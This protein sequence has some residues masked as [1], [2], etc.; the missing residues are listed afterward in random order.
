MCPT[1]STIQTNNY[2]SFNSL[3]GLSAWLISLNATNTIELVDIHPNTT[4]TI[5]FLKSVSSVNSWV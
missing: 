2:V 4:A 3:N 5:K 1:L